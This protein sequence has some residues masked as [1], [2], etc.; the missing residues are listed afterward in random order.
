MLKSILEFIPDEELKIPFNISKKFREVLKNDVR[1][2]FWNVYNDWI[3]RMT[4]H[5]ERENAEEHLDIITRDNGDVVFFLLD[6]R[7]ESEKSVK[8]YFTSFVYN[9]SELFASAG[10]NLEWGLTEDGKFYSEID[11]VDFLDHRSIVNPCRVHNL[12]DIKILAV[13]LCYFPYLKMS[14]ENYHHDYNPELFVKYK[15]DGSLMLRDFQRFMLN[16]YEHTFQNNSKFLIAKFI[17]MSTNAHVQTQY[18]EESD[19][20]CVLLGDMKDEKEMS[21][22]LDDLILYRKSKSYVKQIDQELLEFKDFVSSTWD[23]CYKLEGPD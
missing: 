14:E 2:T 18:F 12:A 1:Y 16:K 4:K 9:N 23:R 5:L 22:E 3:K 17:Q 21:E 7:I 13:K 15:I 8:P 11:D 20:D 10:N 6:L 19:S